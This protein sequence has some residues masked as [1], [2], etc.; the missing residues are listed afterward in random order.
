MI[1]RIAETT[2]TNDL[3]HGA[4]YGHGDVIWAERQTAGRGQR[5]HT[6]TS[7]EGVNLLFSV[8]LCPTFLPAGE[9]FGLSQAVAL[10]LADTFAAFGIDTRIKWTNDIYA[11]DCKLTGILIEHRL[12]GDRLARTVVGVGI[13]VNQKAFDPALP[14]PTSM[15]LEAGRTFDRE[16]VLG[17]FHA[18]LMRRYA[19][20]EAGERAAL[21]AEYRRRMY[22]LDEPQ[23]F[24]LPD[25]SRFTGIVRGVRSTG[26]LLVEHPDGA[27]RDYLFR[28]I[29]FAVKKSS[30]E[31]GMPK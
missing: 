25:G 15:A 26:A 23:A 4:Q 16:E 10:A 27:V 17:R 3:A 21:A 1:H 28:E 6:W 30:S 14:N 12:A 7:P 20:L 5:G 8:V 24:R 31:L 18:A 13:N 9:Q 11:G 29:E 19:A 22:R 2:S